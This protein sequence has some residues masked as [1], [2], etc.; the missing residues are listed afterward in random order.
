MVIRP[1]G[2]NI[3]FEEKKLSQDK[4]RCCFF[5]CDFDHNLIGCC[6]LDGNREG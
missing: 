4:W 2:L 6:G 1:T 5:F 3:G